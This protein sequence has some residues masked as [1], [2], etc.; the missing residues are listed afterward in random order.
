MKREEKTK[1]Q[2]IVELAELH[3]RMAD[4]E[5]KDVEHR[6]AEELTRAARDYAE[7]IIET[8]RKPLAVL[9]ADMKVYSANLSF[10]KMFKVSPEETLGKVL[11]DIGNRQWDTPEVRNIL[12]DMIHQKAKHFNCEVDCVFPFIGHKIIRVNARHLYHE[13]ISGTMVLL[14]FDDITQYKRA[15]EAAQESRRYAESLIEAVRQPIVVLDADFKVLS[16]NR[17]FNTVFQVTS[18]ESI[19]RFIYDLGNRQWDIPELRT[20]LEGILPKNSS[21]DN[22][23]VDH[24]FPAIGHKVMLLNARRIYREGLGTQL[25]LLAM[26]D[27]TERKLQEKELMTAEERYRRI[28]ETA[29]DGLLILDKET[30]AITSANLSVAQLLGHSREELLG[31]KINDI[32]IFKRGLDFRQLVRILSDVGFI[33]YDDIPFDTGGGKR[34]NA[35]IYLVDRAQWIQCNIRDITERK[36]AEAKYRRLAY[37]KELI[38]NSVGEGIFG[39]NL[40]GNVTFINSAAEKMLGWEMEEL[41]NRPIHATLHHSRP[42]KTPYPPEE[43]VLDKALKSGIS[44]TVDS[45]VFWRKDNSSFP[46]EYTT[47]PMIENNK[48]VGAVVT[49]KDITELKRSEDEKGKL[50]GQLRQVQKMEAIGQLAG[51]VAHDFNNI[52]SAIVGYGSLLRKK[53]TAADPLRAYVDLILEAADRATHVTHSLLAFSRK[54]VMNLKPLNLNDVLNRVE[55]FLRRIIGEDIDLK[56]ILSDAELTVMADSVQIEQVLMNLATNARD[57]MPDG[58]SLT[59]RSELKAIDKGFVKAHGYGK[60]GLYAA[61]TVEDT[62]GGVDEKT[63][64]KIFE[65]FFT[66]KEK[67]K[68][69]GLGLAIVYGI[70]KQHKGYINVY[71]DPG[72]GT[73]FTIY[74]PLIAAEKKTPETAVPSSPPRGGTETILV[75]EDNATVRDLMKAVLKEYG[76]T[77]IMAVDGQDA[78]HAFMENRDKIQLVILDMIM[79]KK[80]GTEACGE[81]KKIKPDLKVFFVSGYTADKVR[82]DWITE[83][84]VGL[85]L[86]PV[87]PNDLLIKVRDILDKA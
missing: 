27:I 60:V 30:G 46:V 75:A 76:Y 6:H 87:L 9:D 11:F 39:L 10:Y 38:L 37:Q 15:E 35:E 65:P 58:G 45:E 66:T 18:E 71:S 16:C 74:I 79:P 36:L 81:M 61:L 13:E 22:F 52:L 54:Q 55:R 25:I 24:I 28:F 56:T 72:R 8:V 26:E 51:G 77:V 84:G 14:A 31:K 44:K 5:K 33:H 2:L 68:G 4:L 47:T 41:I 34:V 50:E 83:K 86:K 80:S 29:K 17:S 62:G 42:D 49:F 23:E 19:G 32:K 48:L 12:E 21:F 40:A 82:N 85:L 73:A 20:L 69:T 59:I 43:C 67:G 78:V 70:V 53:M 64:E 3:M 1:D 7:S 57:A 63:R